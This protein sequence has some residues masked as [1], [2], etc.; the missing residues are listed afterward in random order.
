MIF[1]SRLS[2]LEFLLIF[3]SRRVENLINAT[4]FGSLAAKADEMTAASSFIS[5]F[6][7]AGYLSIIIYL[8]PLLLCLFGSQGG[9]VRMSGV[10]G[11]VRGFWVVHA[12]VPLNN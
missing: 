5:F 1:S 10:G 12:R 3:Y 4:Y 2:A 9:T 6:S 8:V 7:L 11:G